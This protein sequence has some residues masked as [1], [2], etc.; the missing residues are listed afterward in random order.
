MKKEWLWLF[1]LAIC[2]LVILPWT[3][4][5]WQQ[6][7]GGERKDFSVRVLLPNGKID[8]IPMEE[9]LVGVVA[10]EM[11]ATFEIEAL[12]AQAVAARSYAAKRINKA[13]TQDIGYDVDTT[14]QT[15]SWLSAADMRKK[16]GGWMGYLRYK[17]RIEQAVK[18]TTGQVLVAGG[19]YIDALYHASSGRKPTEKA[20]DVW[21]AARSYLRNVPAQEDIPSR[22]VQSVS[23]SAQEL[24][25]RLKINNSAKTLTAKDIQL[26]S[27]TGAGR[28]KELLIF[29]KSFSASQLRTLLGLAS[30]DIEWIVKPDQVTFVTYG[31]GHAVGMSQYGANDLAKKG[32]TFSEILAY[33]YPGTALLSLTHK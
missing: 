31:S 23:F 29:G 8:T 22:F 17:G 2:L 13:S 24:A 5:K 12:K 19:D 27:R 1:G 30:T 10:A 25:T 4:L 21:G 11:P 28:V 18:A 15:Q 6:G 16:W 32:K 33:F 20:E 26:L 14:P 7:P 9:Y 3:V